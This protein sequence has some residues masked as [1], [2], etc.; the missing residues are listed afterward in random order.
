MEVE[1]ND[2]KL[3]FLNRCSVGYEYL[4][5]Q[6]ALLRRRL[7]IRVVGEVGRR[8]SLVRRWIGA[9]ERE[10]RRNQK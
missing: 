5:G 3:G 7:K 1:V 10:Y 2:G 6:G 4:I 9:P 8:I